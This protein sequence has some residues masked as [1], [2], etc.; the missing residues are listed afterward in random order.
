MDFNFLHVDSK[1]FAH[2][3]HTQTGKILTALEEGRRL[4][5]VDALLEFSCFRLAAVIYT[6]RKE[7]HEI[8]SQMIDVPTKVGTTQVAEYW[9]KPSK[10]QGELF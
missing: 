3:K 10:Q 6:L 2:G 8:N 4:T 1:E 9:L 5:P 7:G